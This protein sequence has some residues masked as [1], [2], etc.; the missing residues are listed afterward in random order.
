MFQAASWKSMLLL[1]VAIELLPSGFVLAA[2]AEQQAVLKFDAVE[3]Q[4]QSNPSQRKLHGRFLHITDFHPDLY[5]QPHTSTEEN[6]ACHKGKGPAGVYGAET[7]D[8][9][10]PF[11]L[12]NATFDWLAKNVQ[13]EIDFVIWTGD[14]ARHDSDEAIERTEKEVVK[15]NRMIANGLAD[16]F[17]DSHGLTIPIIPTFGNNDILPHNVMTAGPN[18]WLRK[19]LDV[20]HDFIPEAQRHAF[21]YGGWFYTEVVPN[22]LA[23]FS[24]NT[25]YFFDRNAGIDDCVSPSQPGYKQFAW[26][27]AQFSYLRSRGMKAILMGHVPPARTGDKQ[28]WEETCWQK[29]TLWLQQYRDVIVGATYGHMNIDHFLIQD[30]HEIDLD[31]L[32]NNGD[33]SKKSKKG[34]KGKKRKG[35]KSANSFP[36]DEDQSVSIQSG[37]DYLVELREAWSKLPKSSVRQTSDANTE[38]K[39][40]HKK[41]KGKKNSD[42]GGVWAERF[43]LSLISPSVVPNYYP[44]YRIYKYNITGLE[45]ASTWIDVRRGSSLDDE[46]GTMSDF[47]AANQHSLAKNKQID[48]AASKKKEGKKDSSSTLVIPEGPSKTATPGPAYSPQTLSFTGFTQYFANLTHI[49]NDMTSKSAGGDEISP[50]GWNGGKHRGKKPTHE[51]KPRDFN[52]EVEYSTFHDDLYKLNDLTVRSFVELAYRIGQAP[53]DSTTTPGSQLGGSHAEAEDEE[54][55][56]GSD[57]TNDDDDDDEDEDEDDDEIDAEKKKSKKKHKGKKKKHKKK[58]LTELWL[59]FLEHAFVKTKTRDEL[60][61]DL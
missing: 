59:H 12:A 49:N 9:D 22:H 28:L 45:D 47:T 57:D 30:T 23:V 1:L 53:A 55:G 15:T 27:D 21:E 16:A 7:S 3:S 33:K 32:D 18:R 6:Y 10:S 5:Y 14:S 56:K 13:D 58:K 38:K 4:P 25:L 35:H 60:K 42:I 50:R 40:K 11:A 29:Y 34:K 43:Q 37:K 26:L 54:Q 24:L 61:E 41:K 46:N 31:L 8:C 36:D 39:K 2:P 19:Y 44:T 20:W 48:S 17:S 52:Y 51:P